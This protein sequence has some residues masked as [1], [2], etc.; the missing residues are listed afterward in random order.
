MNSRTVQLVRNA[1]KFTCCLTMALFVFG[2]EDEELKQMERETYR[3]ELKAAAAKFGQK[4]HEKYVAIKSAQCKTTAL[5]ALDETDRFFEGLLECKYQYSEERLK[6]L[7][8]IMID[9]EKEKNYVF[10]LKI[11]NPDMLFVM[12]EVDINGDFAGVKYY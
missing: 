2:C 10:T 12:P 6:S 8:A 1:Y 7:K 9:T 3:A 11:D 4:E 5:I